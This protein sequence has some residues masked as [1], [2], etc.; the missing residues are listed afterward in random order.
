MSL[1]NRLNQLKDKM[2]ANPSHIEGM[3][4][5]FSFVITDVEDTWSVEINKNQVHLINELLDEPTCLLKMDQ[6]HFEKLLEGKLNATTAFMMGKIKAKGDLSEA[7][8]LQKIL[9]Y[10]Q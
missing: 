4:S 7:L 1:E 2:N 8:K 9:T 10:Y 5:T 3:T 6:S